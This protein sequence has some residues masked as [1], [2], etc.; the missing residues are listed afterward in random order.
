M[1]LV[2]VTRWLS[3]TLWLILSAQFHVQGRETPWVPLAHTPSVFLVFGKE[4]HGGLHSQY[5]FLDHGVLEHG[6][7]EHGVL[8][9]R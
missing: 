5:G 4:R 1:T 8:E 9:H 2:P 6:V 7:L 3:R